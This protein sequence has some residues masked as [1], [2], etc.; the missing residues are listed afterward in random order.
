MTSGWV[1][2]PRTRIEREASRGKSHTLVAVALLI[3]ATV[4][5]PQHSL[6]ATF[7]VD[8][9]DDVASAATCSDTTANDCSLRGAIAA[10]NAAAGSTVVVPAGQYPLTTS[11]TCAFTSRYGTSFVG[12]TA[13]C[14]RVAMTV[15]G[16]GASTTTVDGGNLAE[17]FMVG[18]S[19][20]VVL[21]GLTIQHGLFNVSSLYGPGGAINNAASLTLDGCVVRDNVSVG[22]AGAIYNSGELTVRRS[23]I[24]NNTAGESHGGGAIFSDESTRLDIIDSTISGNSCGNGGGGVMNFYGTLTVSGSTISGNT[25]GNYAGGVWNLGGSMLMLNST[26]SGN[27]NAHSYGG[28]FWNT[29]TAELRNVT[30]TG[31]RAGSASGNGLGGGIATTSGTLRLANTIVAGNTATYFSVVDAGPD[32][33]ATFTSL[34]HN[35]IGFQD[36]NCVITGDTTGNL[37][38]VDAKLGPLTDN[39]GPTDTHTLLPGSAAL[40]AGDPATPGSGDGACPP[41]ISAD[42]CGRR[43]RA[44]TSARSRSCPASRSTRRPPIAAATAARSSRT[45]RAMRSTTARPSACGAPA[46]ATSSARPPPW[47]AAAPV[48]RPRSI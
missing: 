21:S 6:A 20:E 14:I 17:V 30:I 40:D 12:T 18:Q 47:T 45:S 3:I 8:R 46:R 38:N 11:G 23:T 10:A 36:K 7:V 15:A 35:L 5:A 37:A 25:A 28:G 48:S 39:G 33:Y 9:T 42:S 22:A 4:A 32:C 19:G 1:A 27:S 2:R 26:I 29:G 43:V 41:S 31:N 13:L 24:A 16:A 44:A 34:G